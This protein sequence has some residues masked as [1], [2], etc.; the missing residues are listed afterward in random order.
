MS[1]LSKLIYRFSAIPI[2]IT[3]GL[4]IDIAPLNRDQKVAVTEETLLNIPG[5]KTPVITVFKNY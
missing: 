1:F 4:F 2:K 3:A 5:R